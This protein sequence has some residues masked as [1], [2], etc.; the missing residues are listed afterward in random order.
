MVQVVLALVLL[1]TLVCAG[2][3][4]ISICRR[5]PIPASGSGWM[6]SREIAVVEKDI[7][8][9]KEVILFA[10]EIRLPS[11][12]NYQ[13]MLMAVLDNFVEAVEYNFLVPAEFYDTE[14]KRAIA[15]YRTIESLA[16]QYA[17]EELPEELFS[18]HRYPHDAR[19]SDYPYLFYR[20]GEDEGGYVVAYR[21][22][23]RG[24]GISDQYQR[25]EPEV[26]MTILSHI[27]P[28]LGDRQ[29]VEGRVQVVDTTNVLPME[30][31]K[32]IRSA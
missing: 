17:E 2:W 12:D 13:E 21:G 6:T 23:E 26:A 16:Q 27:S 11:K 32:R 25:L 7:S 3:L 14:G 28:Y 1:S 15:H 8:D 29:G 22:M 30:D 31:K 20:Y 24:V 9:L 10:D 18:L 4:A 19:A 5:P